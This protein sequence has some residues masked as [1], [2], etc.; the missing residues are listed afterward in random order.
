MGDAD[1]ARLTLALVLISPTSLRQGEI[2]LSMSSYSRS[3]PGDPGP[4]TSKRRRA[5]TFE[6]ETAHER[7]QRL[8]RLKSAYERGKVPAKPQSRNEL[9]VLKERHQCAPS[10]SCSPARRLAP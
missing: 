6:P 7:H 9:D 4:S 3:Y 5:E 8:Y 2:Q 1:L 10:S